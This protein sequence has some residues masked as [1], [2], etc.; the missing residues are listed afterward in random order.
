MAFESSATTIDGVLGEYE[1][2]HDW[3]VQRNPRQVMSARD[4]AE[5]ISQHT[6]LI[7]RPYEGYRCGTGLMITNTGFIIT[8]YHVL[9]HLIAKA[10]STLDTPQPSLAIRRGHFMHMHADYERLRITDRNGETYHVKYV[11][12]DSKR[13]DLVLL[14]AEIP[15][16]RPAAIP[17]LVGSRRARLGEQVR[18]VGAAPY[19]QTAFGEVIDAYSTSRV[20][21]YPRVR[22]VFFT[23]AVLSSDFS[24]G[25][26]ISEQG[27]LLGIIRGGRKTLD[28]LFLEL[29]F[30]NERV[31]SCGIYAAHISS[32]VEREL[33]TVFV[34]GLL[35]KMFGVK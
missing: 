4:S 32:L 11:A 16:R 3:S 14:K 22:G 23:D 10:T 25:P 9:D 7:T 5:Q 6:V 30:V 28:N 34:L 12:V 29:G 33:N 18:I 15:A 24:G 35:E 2:L 31:S 21:G 1:P 19:F 27:E 17:M 26:I 20:R 13:N 8:N